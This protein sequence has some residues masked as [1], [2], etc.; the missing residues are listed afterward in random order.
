MAELCGSVV[1]DRE[2][3]S[4]LQLERL[5]YK[6]ALPDCLANA[7]AISVVPGELTAAPSASDER[8]LHSWLPHIVGK[9]LVSLSSSTA[10]AAVSAGRTRT[11]GV[12]FCG[13]QCPGGNNIVSGLYDFC[14]ASPDTRVIGFVGGT[15]GLFDG[16]YITITPEL[17]ASFRN[18]GGYHMLGRSVDKIRTATGQ[19]AALA[20][21]TS[22]KLDGLVLVGGT[23]TNTDAAHLAEYFAAHQQPGS[24]TAV[25]GVP[26][27]IDGDVHS[28][29]VEQTLGFDTAT[30][31]Y[32]QLVGN[33]ATDGNSAKKYWFFIRLM[34]RHASRIALEVALQTHPNAVLLAEEIEARKLTL[35]DVVNELADLVAA[36][37]AAGKNFG[38]V[39]LPEGLV[40]SI[41]ELRALIAEM[42]ALFAEG[43]TQDAV[44]A[45][46]TPWS[47]AVLS[48]LPAFI[49]SQLFLERESSGAIQLSQISTERLLAELVG[50]ELGRRKARGLFKGKYSS[51]SHFFGYQARS[52][53][54]S[55]FDCSYGDSLGRTAAALALAGCNGYMATV[56]N[57]TAPVSEWKPLGVPLTAMMSVPAP[58]SVSAQA[59]AVL[60]KRSALG[61]EALRG[62][63]P[64]IESALV[65][66]HS[67]PFKLLKARSPAWSLGELYRNPGPIQFY[68]GPSS[69]ADN[70]TLS[71]RHDNSD[72]LVRIERLRAALES[73]RD[74]CRPGVSDSI[75]DAALTGATSLAHILAVMR[76]RE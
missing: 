25:I 15:Q 20:T 5:L 17:L 46:L 50:D 9:P 26:A 39:V 33:M 55:I 58:G 64:V 76:E 36:R 37:S 49:S 4:E 21:C 18:Q 3:Y 10:P 45:R 12:V 24:R 68:S 54:P 38:L 47:Q 7:A 59:Y 13:R 56:R 61:G 66:V 35:T 52:S 28:Q 65:S 31:V 62:V 67:G 11:V 16:K 69:S 43:V 42:N 1:I 2:N 44:P 19:A 14:T 40:Q 57:L 70:V 72:Y 74:V 63:R 6:P 8:T 71:L 53:L 30:R 29:F 32:S 23:F 48:Y 22:L 34:G 27:T 51:I 73:C 60:E 41:P 75:L